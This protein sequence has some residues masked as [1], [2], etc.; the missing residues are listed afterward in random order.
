[1][2]AGMVRERALTFFWSVHRCLRTHSVFASFHL[3]N[4]IALL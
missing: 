1:M 2:L 3:S 4:P